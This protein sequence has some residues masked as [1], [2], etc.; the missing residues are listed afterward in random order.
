MYDLRV[1]IL[2]LSANKISLSVG[3]SDPTCCEK[4][5]LILNMK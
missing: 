5:L 2:V 3:L 4:H 1:F